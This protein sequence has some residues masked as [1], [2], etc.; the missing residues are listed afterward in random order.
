MK[1]RHCGSELTLPFI[2]L[3]HGPPIERV[4]HR[5][6]LE[7]AGEMVSVA[8][9]GVHRMLVGADRGLRP[10]RRAIL[11]PTTPISVRFRQPGCSMPNI[12]C[13]L[14]LNASV[15][16]KIRRWSRSPPTMATCC[17]TSRLAAS[18]ASASSPPPARQGSRATGAFE[19][20]RSF[21]GVAWPPTCCRRQAG[22][23]DGGQQ[24]AR[25][26]AGHQRFCRRLRH[27]A[28]AAGRGH[29]RVSAPVANWLQENQF[30]TIY[31]E[32]FSYLS[33]TAVNR[34]FAANGL[35]VFDVEEHPTHGGSL[36]VFAQRSD[37][38]QQAAQRPC[39][40]TAPA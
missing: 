1:C 31:H 14:R 32:H 21:F 6:R 11:E 33:L 29:L 22:R 15:S 23:P 25:P 37:T 28:Q 26:C 10:P 16:A 39:G 24:R 9:A 19:S 40:R 27:A 35:A 5:G 7:R 30:D 4:P 17:S 13:D 2:D 36:R 38:G 8:R 20:S 3:G 34:I 18:P 12:T